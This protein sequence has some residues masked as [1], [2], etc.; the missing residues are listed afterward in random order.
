MLPVLYSYR[1][2]PYAMR[3]RIALVR[4]KVSFVLRE[5]DLQNKSPIFLKISGKG[6]VPALVFPNGDIMD[7]SLD[8]V[9]Y[10]YKDQQDHEQYFDL[11]KQLNNYFI[12]SVTRFKYHERYSEI[13]VQQAKDNIKGYFKQLDTLL[14]Q[15][16]YLLSSEFAKADN[17][18]LPFVRQVYRADEVFFEALPFENLKRWLFTIINS[19]WFDVVM[20][21][22]SIW[23]PD[24]NPMI[25]PCSE[26]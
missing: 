21:K 11:L 25:L 6:T 13:E 3:A 15:Q 9:D 2:C 7:E 18:I 22:C 8:I 16:R 26:V 20:V 19:D 12:Q 1:R 14:A 5:I 10:F 17:V 24:Q 23:Q 4:A